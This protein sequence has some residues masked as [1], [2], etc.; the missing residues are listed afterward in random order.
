MRYRIEAGNT[1]IGVDGARLIAPDGAFDLIAATDA[2]MRPGLI[3]AHDHLHRN[4]YPRL[5][6]PPYTDAYAWG[7]D[8]HTRYADE[9]TRARALPRRDALLF[10][11]LKNLLGGV[12]TVVHH[13]AWE[14]DFARGF[15]LEVLRV[16]NLHSL[17]FDRAAVSAAA[18]ESP[19][20]A[21]PFTMHL[22]EGIDAAAAEEI[23]SLERIGLLNEQLIAV[24]VVGADDDGI[25]RIRNARA[26]VAWCPSSNQFLFGRTCPPPLFDGVDVLLGT[27]AMLTGTGSMFDELRVARALGLL[28]ETRLEAAVG[29]TAARRLA[30]G[31]RTLTPGALAQLLL[32]RCPLLDATTRDIALVVVNG[33][34]VFGDAEFED[35]FRALDV[36]SDVIT[37]DGAEKRII[38][39]LAT[40]AANV[41]EQWPESARLLTSMHPV[42]QS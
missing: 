27:D 42:T 29:A 5:G 31:T 11:A 38:R 26:A 2:A 22:A 12:T 7:R 23:R 21:R 35:L 28:S 34:P 10:G 17:G 13:D 37:V 33:R 1:A 19:G 16:R 18:S 25:R 3:N 20:D 41:V 4:H 15:P 30:L 14:P 24:H 9:I 36:P 8:L 39:P 32:L 40:I 6:A